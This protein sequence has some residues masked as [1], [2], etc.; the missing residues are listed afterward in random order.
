M[1]TIES[2]PRPADAVRPAAVHLRCTGFAKRFGD[3]A[4]VAGVDL[5]IQRGS[6]VVLLGASG[7]G[8]T[9]LL[10][11]IAGLV[12]PDAGSLSL[13]GADL[14]RTPAARRNFGFVFQAYALF[15]TKT[16]LDNIAFPLMIRGA[17]PADRRARVDELATLMQ[18]GDLLL[19]FPHELSGGQQQR[20]AL[21]RALAARPALLLLDEPLSALDARIRLRLRNELHELVRR[22]GVTTIY[23]THDQEEAL[24]LADRIVVMDQGR[25]VQD[26]TPEEIYLRPAS[27]HVASFVGRATLVAATACPDGSIRFDGGGELSGLRHDVPPGRACTVAIRPEFVTLVPMAGAPLVAAVARPVFMGSHMRVAL[28]GP[29]GLSLEADVDLRRWRMLGIRAG[30]R[31]GLEIDERNI[32]VI[33]DGAG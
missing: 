23:V 32:V 14:T 21:A 2:R 15:P 4:A 30:D 13:D 28:D 5:E 24:E 12:E 22:V 27:R 18:I 20:V 9:T 17:T 11:M 25:I 31:V 1:T 7:C 19:R 16:V 33:A 10:R 29:W 26:D 3:V 8:K 6:F